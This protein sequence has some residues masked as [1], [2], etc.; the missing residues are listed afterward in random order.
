MKNT[1]IV[2]IFVIA[3]VCRAS[4]TNCEEELKNARGKGTLELAE[5]LSFKGST[6][7]MAQLV[8]MSPQF[9]ESG[10]LYAGVL[11]QVKAALQQN[12]SSVGRGGTT[13]LVSKGLSARILSIASEYGALKESSS[14]QSVTVQGTLDGVPVALIRNGFF[15]E[16]ASRLIMQQPCFDHGLLQVLNRTSYSVSFNTSQ[17][18]QTVS[19]TAAGQPQGN[20]Q[21]VTF[22]ANARQINQV[23]GKV[24]ILPG[25]PATSARFV[26][27]VKKLF[28]PKNPS[29]SE[30]GTD[31]KTAGKSLKEAGKPLK[32][33]EDKVNKLSDMPAEDLVRICGAD[34]PG[35]ECDN[36]SIWRAKSIKLI[37]AAK[38]GREL[39][40]VWKDLGCSLVVALG[41]PSPSN[42][43]G[44][45]TRC[46]VLSGVRGVRDAKSTLLSD[47]LE[48]G[49]AYT[50][51]IL[52]QQQ[53][54]NSLRSNPV[55]T[56]EYDE[57]R[58][59]N[60]PTNSVFKL[61]YGQTFSRWTV[62][63]NGAASIYDTTPSANIPGAGRLRDEQF[64]A[65]LDR[66]FGNLAPLG[67]IS[68]SVAYYF[69]YQAS[70]AILN[71]TPG[72]PVSGVTFTGLPATATQ[73]FA[74]K[75]NIHVA[76]GRIALGPAS[77]SIK[78][79]I[80]VSWS[81]RTELINKPAWRGQ[82]GISY[83]FD[84]LFGHNGTK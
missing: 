41:G 29:A 2:A 45:S 81:N 20:A 62:T 33:L 13:N 76:Q 61:I 74:Q 49:Q 30:E 72:E 39:S 48:Y 26:D 80:S 22:T 64:G 68:G 19:G 84:S 40:S 59:A 44:T 51:F 16:C 1:L 78:V 24:V 11:R 6:E 28:D 54:S 66:N 15:S 50:E 36:F 57:N 37:Q 38:E 56:F 17:N 55:L 9:Q 7:C 43:L 60:Q 34:T 12:G 5:M 75:G 32:T 82:I 70:P 31:V 3:A 47:A 73:V 79:P 10:T 52:A 69:Q 77:S 8:L 63:A 25:R 23:S 71:V 27:E 83:D 4:A 35:R 14:N 18:S 67:P 65:E 42:S 53:F 21:P 58:P 46:N